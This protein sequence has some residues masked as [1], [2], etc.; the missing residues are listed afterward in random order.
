MEPR[1]DQSIPHKPINGQVVI[2][3]RSLFGFQ[4]FALVL[5]DGPPSLFLGTDQRVG[6]GEQD[7]F[8]PAGHVLGYHPTITPE[9]TLI[10]WPPI[11]VNQAHWYYAPFAAPPSNSS[12]RPPPR[13]MAGQ[14]ASTRQDAGNLRRSIK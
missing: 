1:P 9:R 12:N 10:P 2:A 5:L 6:R 14:L 13:P 3:D 11:A 7:G 4:C 8:F